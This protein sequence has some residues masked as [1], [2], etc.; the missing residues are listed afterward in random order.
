[1]ILVTFTAFSAISVFL[2]ITTTRHSQHRAAV[3]QV[4]ARQRAVA[5]RYVN[6]VLLVSSGGKADPAATAGLLT[7]SADA[8]LDG[9]EAPD[10]PGDDDAAALPAQPGAV[11]GAQPQQERGWAHARAGRGQALLAQKTPSAVPLPA[12]E[13]IAPPEPLTRLRVLSAL[14]ANT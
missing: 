7:K 12:G 1:A 13:H 10:L 11:I 2:S 8:L 9:G 3:L 14:T 6:E 4:A 5:E